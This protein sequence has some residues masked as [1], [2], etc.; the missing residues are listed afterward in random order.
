[1]IGRRFGLALIGVV[2]VAWILGA[3]WVSISHG[4]TE[5][6]F[7]DALGGL[8]FLIGGLIAMDRRPGN[9]IGP[10]MLG[11]AFVPYL[12]NFGNV[13]V[14]PLPL[15]GVISGQVAAPMLAHIALAYPTGK[16]R[17]GLDRAVVATIYG[18]ATAVNL[19]IILVFDPRAGGCGRCVREW[20]V[21]PNRS[22][23]D[24][25]L[26]AYQR[27]GFVLALAFLVAVALRWRRATPAERRDLTPLWI[28]VSII[29]VV[30]LLQAFASPFVDDPFAY[31]LWELQ[32]VAQIGLPAVFVWGLLSSRLA[33]SAVGDL[34]VA[35]QQPL[36]PGEL[37]APL[38]RTL[39]DPSLELLYPLDGQ[40]RWVDADGRAAPLADGL[41]SVTIV[42][43]D[44]Q[45]LAALKHDPGLDPELV[46]AAAAAAGMS[47][48]NERLH[49]EVRAQLEEVRQSRRRIVEAGDR[50]RRRIERNLH[51]GAQQRLAAL[52]LSLA[53]LRD[54][55]RADAATAASLAEAGDQL[56]QAIGELRELARGIHPAILTEEGLT[57]AVE[58]LVDRSALTVLVKAD[59]DDRLPEPVEAV[60]YFVVA[61]S[62]TNVAR[63]AGT[64]QVRVE[65]ARQNGSLR[66]EVA[67]DGVG[68]ADPSRGSGLRGLD[69]RVAAVHGRFLVE[70]PDGGGTRVLAE[71]PC[72]G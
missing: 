48:E 42:Q 47:I 15:L 3:E 55:G 33:R 28:A 27:I 7:I 64:C 67:D 66:V 22:V 53:M 11:V 61:E 31:L 19:V 52:A 51:D 2:G 62:L 18:A 54:G 8:A 58:S 43:R 25:V 40:D 44:G 12:G 4:V 20:A 68:G 65:L 37:R 60:A 10:L 39:G 5:N 56:R 38:A 63:Y 21:F 24:G 50:E 57:A 14:T 9:V 23:F 32:G 49:A 17:S 26:S 36:R 29:A 16:L 71:I 1:M 34:V 30:Y 72:D 69:D 13:Q 35:L 45:T 59:L 6:H 46:R 41:A 70:T